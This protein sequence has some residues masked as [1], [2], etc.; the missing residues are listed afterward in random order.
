MNDESMRILKIEQV[1]LLEYEQ[2]FNLL[3]L[4]NVSSMTSNLKIE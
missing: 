4:V 3:S 1:Q 2:S